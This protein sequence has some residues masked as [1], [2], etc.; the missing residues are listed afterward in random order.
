M[1]SR[2]KGLA[3]FQQ[4]LLQCNLHEEIAHFSHIQANLHFF[5][6]DLPTSWKITVIN[7]YA[8]VLTFSGTML[9][10]NKVWVPQ[11]IVITT[12]KQVGYQLVSSHSGFLQTEQS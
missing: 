4:S 6:K 2:K 7:L 5:C 11:N 3:V 1:D 9:N 8:G 12:P 10:T